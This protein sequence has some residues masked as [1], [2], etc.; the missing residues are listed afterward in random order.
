MEQGRK[1]M[2]H[3]LLR[4]GKR[5]NN[6]YSHGFSVS[7]IQTLSSIFQAF[8]PCSNI[9]GP[10]SPLP[11]EVQYSPLISVLLQMRPSQSYFM[12]LSNLLSLLCFAWWCLCVGC[13]DNEEESV[14]RSCEVDKINTQL[15]FNKTGIF[16]A[17]WICV[18][19]LE[20]PIY[21]Q[22]FGIT[23]EQKRADPV[24]MVITN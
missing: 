10:Q 21:F 18:S 1:N 20:L 5:K 7:Q 24:Q 3:I 17:M 14:T 6:G 8:I 19:G 22:V 23:I 12:V 13:R 15:T 4:G 9:S 16:V 11:D 2:S